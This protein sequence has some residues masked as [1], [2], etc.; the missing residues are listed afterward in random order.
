[1]YVRKTLDVWHCRIFIIL[2]VILQYDRFC[3]ISILRVAHT[4]TEQSHCTTET[5]FSGIQHRPVNT[6]PNNHVP[7]NNPPASTSLLE[8]YHL[9]IEEDIIIEL[10]KGAQLAIPDPCCLS[11]PD[12]STLVFHRV[13]RRGA[14]PIVDATT[15]GVAAYILSG[16]AKEVEGKIRATMALGYHLQ[17]V[18]GYTHS[19]LHHFCNL[20]LSHSLKL[21]T[22]YM[23]RV[24]YM[25]QH[26]TT[27][28]IETQSLRLQWQRDN[29][30]DELFDEVWDFG[31]EVK[32]VLMRI[33]QAYNEFVA[34]PPNATPPD[35]TANMVNI[36]TEVRLVLKLY[37]AHGGSP[38][39]EFR[40]MW[41]SWL[42]YLSPIGWSGRTIVAHNNTLNNNIRQLSDIVNLRFDIVTQ[43]I[44]QASQ[45]S[46]QSQNRQFIERTDIRGMYEKKIQCNDE[47]YE[48]KMNEVED[49]YESKLRVIEDK[50]ESKL[51]VMEKK[52]QAIVSD[53]TE[54]R[55]LIFE[56][57]IISTGMVNKMKGIEEY[58][59]QLEKEVSLINAANHRLEKEVKL[60]KAA[61]QRLGI[62]VYDKG[63]RIRVLLTKMHLKDEE[64]KYLEAAATRGGNRSWSEKVDNRQLKRVRMD[65]VG[66]RDTRRR[67]T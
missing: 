14:F 31:F 11:F 6:S 1:M 45:V 16:L 9:G 32:N 57:D 41:R 29:H 21:P 24:V 34:N 35:E 49:K 4:F 2:N 37:L 67:H 62:D 59:Q 39:S 42:P 26:N 27:P 17:L 23:G 40:E 28:S 18:N 20:V 51:R 5:M 15:K 19:T 50:Y 61:N 8:V 56:K 60:I 3:N 30:A 66:T 47:K 53:N 22:E 7:I 63:E 58:K 52:Y 33:Q 38:P 55:Q 46:Q 43:S 13:N 25:V 65:N 48:S 10:R 64:I 12:E 36:R 54:M 44:D